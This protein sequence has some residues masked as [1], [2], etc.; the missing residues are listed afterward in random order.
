MTDIFTCRWDLA[1]CPWTKQ[2]NLGKCSNEKLGTS[3]LV[4]DGTL[5]R[6]LISH[7]HSAI[8]IMLK[9]LIYLG[10]L[11][12]CCFP[13]F[14]LT[15]KSFAE[16]CK[17]METSKEKFFFDNLKKSLVEVSFHFY[18]Q[19]CKNIL[20]WVT[21]LWTYFLQLVRKSNKPVSD[22]VK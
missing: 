2:S 18:Q 22:H 11:W 21:F 8:L 1:S 7:Q 9:Y 14:A 13:P 10:L 20:E 15:W 3:T 12:R 17:I 4:N 19:L 5:R 16:S 6:Q